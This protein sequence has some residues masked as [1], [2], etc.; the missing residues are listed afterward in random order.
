MEINSIQSAGMNPEPL[1]G[2]SSQEQGPSFGK[3][4]E[5]AV[6]AVNQD[7]HE[8]D[9]AARNFG[10][11]DAQSLQETMITMEKAD[12]TLRLLTQVRNRAVEAYQEVMRMQI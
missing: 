11:G 12:I 5:R 9:T 1:S 10:I 8:A 4:L 7:Q 2:S 6:E 3:V